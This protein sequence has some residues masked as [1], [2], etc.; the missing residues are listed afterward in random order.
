MKTKN[1]A[2]KRKTKHS[3]RDKYKNKQLKEKYW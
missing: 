2:G 1:Y 3:K